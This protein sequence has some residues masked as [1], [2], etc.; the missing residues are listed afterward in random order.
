MSINFTT[1][2]EFEG[3]VYVKGHYDDS[4]CR[5]DATLKKHVNL[6]V[7][8]SMFITKI[9]KSYHI[10]CFYTETDRIVTT[11]LDVR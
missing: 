4:L 3:H 6:T 2:K 11:R 8:F 5:V 7:P 9:D 10:K 1:Q